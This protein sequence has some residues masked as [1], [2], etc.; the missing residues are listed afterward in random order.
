VSLLPRLSFSDD[1]LALEA[2][3][4]SLS[5]RALARRAAFHVDALRAQGLVPGDRIAVF[6]EP[7]CHTL[8]AIVGQALAGFVSVP[9]NPKSGERELAHVLSDAAPKLVVGLEGEALARVRRLAPDVPVLVPV[10]EEATH[11]IPPMPVTDAPLL[12]LYT[13][14]TTGSPKGAV[15]SGRNVAA[16]I[17]GLA[18]AW[19]WTDRDIVVHA[20]PL[21]HVHGLVLGLLGSLRTGGALI[22]RERFDPSDLAEALTRGTMLFAVPTMYQRL[23]DAA[24]SAPAVCDALRGAR[25][26]ISG[27]APLA[28]REHL[29]IESLTGR[30]VHER[31]GLT[32]S[33]IDCAIP[34][35]DPPR[36]GYVGRA[37][38]GCSVRLV[39]ESRE[40]LDVSDDATM[41]EVAVRG[42][43]IFAGYLGREEATRAVLDADGWFYTGDLATRT[44]DGYI[45]IVGRRAT[46]LI[47]SG[48]YKIGAGEIE[49]A[50][51]ERGEVLEAAVLGVPDDDLGER[52]VAWVVLREGAAEDE[53]GL[54][55]HV[56][57]MLA[58]HKRPRAIHFVH[59]L[60]RNAMGKVQK[61][62]LLKSL[63]E[64]ASV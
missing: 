24:E 51:L 38:P 31:Y 11:A 63:T 29:R 52:I 14:G 60:P 6:A 40:T 12:V 15:L 25:L 53:A 16:N 45:R 43:Q 57:Q 49:A 5:A 37:V 33:L 54:V 13:S 47:K 62:L 50:L 34:A 39:T 35:S 2:A 20:L 19:A 9:M 23:A 18:K 44:A 4:V 1:R 8:V 48:G 64:S 56:A 58:P 59:A 27:S 55:A 28:V 46:D 32:E 17:D 10:G 7:S 30:G 42:P 61:P 22:V 41:G 36:P 26:L 21:F 3:G